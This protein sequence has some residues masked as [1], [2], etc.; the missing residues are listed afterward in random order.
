MT[1]DP[2]FTAQLSPA[3]LARLDQLSTDF[4]G[5]LL[6]FSH[7]ILQRDAAFPSLVELGLAPEHAELLYRKVP[8]RWQDVLMIGRLDVNTDGE[9]FVSYELNGDQPGGL[10][11]VAELWHGR[12]TPA[13]EAPPCPEYRAYL[14]AAAGYYRVRSSRRDPAGILLLPNG[15]AQL[16]MEQRELAAYFGQPVHVAT[17]LSRLR[18]D[19]REL[20]YQDEAGR[21]HVIDLVFRCPRVNIYQLVASDY[22]PIREAYLADAAVLVNPA[23]A[24]VAGSKSLYGLLADPRRQDAAQLSDGQ[25]EAVLALLPQTIFVDESNVAQLRAERAQWVLK[26]ALGGRG[27]RVW[28]GADTSDE[29]WAALLAAREPGFT[30]Q[31]F[32]PPYRLPIRVDGAPADERPS[33]P[34]SIAPF[35]TGG[36]SPGVAGY[37]VR[38]VI[39]VAGDRAELENVKLNLLGANDYVGDDGTLR[40]R[41]VGIGRLGSLD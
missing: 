34:I 29:A 25:R 23:H 33:V 6:T 4:V 36:E 38:A 21:R 14:S 8:E 12:K 15:Y 16:A 5:A 17:D 37:L 11:M 35:V 41:V 30:C 28:L 19:G 27:Q 18:F 7:R 1:Q 32:R 2:A 10:A 31:E 9:A 3:Q 13:P 40:H 26:A 24:R 20:G 39:P 22:A